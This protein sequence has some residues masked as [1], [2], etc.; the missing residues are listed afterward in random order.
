MPIDIYN[1]SVFELKPEIC[2]RKSLPALRY[3]EAGIPKLNFMLAA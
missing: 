1:K 3:G 2:I